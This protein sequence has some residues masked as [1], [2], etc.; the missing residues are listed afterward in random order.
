MPR[1][2]KLPSNANASSKSTI[3]VI[4]GPVFAGNSVAI[5]N[6]GNVLQKV[7][8]NGG[9]LVTDDPKKA[10][11][12]FGYIIGTGVNGGHFVATD[13]EFPPISGQ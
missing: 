1:I 6:Q 11:N 2:T 7:Q 10:V 3:M 9:T 4:N 13:V 8:G 12:F 5:V